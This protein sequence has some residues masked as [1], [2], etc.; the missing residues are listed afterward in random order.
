[1][2]WFCCSGS[3]PTSLALPLQRKAVSI[4]L[5][6][7]LSPRA[8]VYP[9][10]LVLAVLLPSLPFTGLVNSPQF[11]KMDHLM[12]TPNPTTI[13]NYLSIHVD[14]SSQTEASQFLDGYISSDLLLH[15]T[16]DA[17]APHLALKCL[18]TLQNPIYFTSHLFLQLPSL[19][20]S[21]SL[22]S[23]RSASSPALHSSS[24]TSWHHSLFCSASAWKYN[25]LRKEC[26]SDS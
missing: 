26:L 23:M 17:Q 16:S 7:D 21:S 25:I 15:S 3:Y 19:R 2:D 12:I 18:H 6:G 10:G 4:Y 9:A 8:M 5:D 11:W 24:C 14:N 1:M 13:L 20:C 22:I